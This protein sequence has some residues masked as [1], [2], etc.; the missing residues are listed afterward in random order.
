MK[1][2]IEY[3]GFIGTVGVSEEDGSFGGHLLVKDSHVIFSGRNY[4]EMI[5]DFHDCVDFY[6]E[7]KKL[8]NETMNNLFKGSFNVR[9]KPQVHKDAV[10]YAKEHNTSLN[11][12]VEA[13]IEEKIY[14]KE[15]TL[16]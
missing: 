12:I 3:K 13:A 1:N 8:K 6:I 5:E 11:K 14:G 4:K 10:I 15:K 9:V 7:D 16:I 2:T